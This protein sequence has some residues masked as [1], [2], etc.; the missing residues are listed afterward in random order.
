MIKSL[1]FQLAFA[2]AFCCA[3]SSPLLW[4]IS[5]PSPTF[6]LESYS[7][8]ARGVVLSPDN[9]G[10][11]V[12]FS[13]A[14]GKAVWNSSALSGNPLV[15]PITGEVALFGSNTVTMI[16]PDT[17]KTLWIG[18]ISG[19]CESTFAG[20]YLI[21]DD[22]CGG[23]QF[24]AHGWSTKTGE[25]LYMIPRTA[26]YQSD[27]IGGNEN[28]AIQRF[29]WDEGFWFINPAT[30]KIL[31]MSNFPFDLD[32]AVVMPRVSGS[33]ATVVS[34][35]SASVISFDV[36]T[37]K[38]HFNTSLPHNLT[39]DQ[40]YGVTNGAGD[41]VAFATNPDDHSP[42]I[43]VAV[44]VKTGNI[45]TAFAAPPSS[46]STNPSIK[47]IIVPL[48]CGHW[49]VSVEI[50]ETFW[51][52]SQTYWFIKTAKAFD[53]DGKLM[54]K[55]AFDTDTNWTLNARPTCSDQGVLFLQVNNYDD[56][57]SQ[58]DFLWAL[59]MTHKTKN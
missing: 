33:D 9:N 57:N 17:G 15:D 18:N 45:L 38:T 8:W 10:G 42:A 7:L 44:N 16:Q 12:A 41:M 46:N 3:F 56:S 20:G 55:Y 11:I 52:D 54:M 40:G 19:P 36:F 2:S 21:A 4:N 26:L 13:A 1:L 35:S 58:S 50:D 51:T 48:V 14:T 5:V 43:F 59:D 25:Q 47:H 32:V 6:T 29:I 28:V 37:L 24:N 23:T 39:C 34:C 53:S 30:G 22:S 49:V 31:D 27:F